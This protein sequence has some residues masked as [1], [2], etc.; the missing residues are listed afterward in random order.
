VKTLTLTLALL[1]LLSAHGQITTT[2][3]AEASKETVKQYDSTENFLGQSAMEY[4]G[5]ELYLKPL[6]KEARN[7]GYQGFLIDYTMILESRSNIYKRNG[8]TWWSDYSSLAERYF[9]VVDVL[10]RNEFDK[11]FYLKLQDK[12]NK[13]VFYYKYDPEGNFPFVVTGYFLKNK[14]ACV[15]KKFVIRG[16]WR[17]NVD[18]PIVDIKTGKPILGFGIGKIWS[19]TDLTVEEKY[20]TLSYIIEN[21]KHEQLTLN[22]SDAKYNTWTFEYNKALAY[23]KK[24]GN[25]TWRLILQA[26]VQTG[27]TKEACKLSWGEPQDASKGISTAGSDIDIW[28]Y[29]GNT[30][31]FKNGVLF[32]LK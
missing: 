2:K 6:S 20:Y 19:V 27:M 18:T 3:I 7:L 13:D 22:V 5:Q 10:K 15:G 24:Y 9:L 30:L 14:V 11:Y 12:I 16:N 21:E 1:S 4:K 23:Q 28:S 17:G 26:K 31:Y 25:E 32:A 8:S 29:S